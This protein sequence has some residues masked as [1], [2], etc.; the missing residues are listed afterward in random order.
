M[1]EDIY[2]LL[3]LNNKKIDTLIELMYHNNYLL[4]FYFEKKIRE[5]PITK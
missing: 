5:H 1:E 2:V 3:Q 4:R